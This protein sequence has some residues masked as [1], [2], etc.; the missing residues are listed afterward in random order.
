MQEDFVTSSYSKADKLGID[1]AR[2]KIEHGR[3]II[4]QVT[5]GAAGQ[6]WREK[7]SKNGLLRPSF[8]TTYFLSAGANFLMD[9]ISRNRFRKMI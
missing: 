8:V 3:N 6:A 2:A 4:T 9:A 5:K 7:L 1:Q